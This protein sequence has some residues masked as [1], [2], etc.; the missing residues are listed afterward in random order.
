VTPRGLGGLHARFPKGWIA[1]YNQA[2]GCALRAMLATFHSFTMDLERRKC[3]SLVVVVVVQEEED[4]FFKSCRQI[5]T[6]S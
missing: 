2:L 5:E 3:S 6:N 1:T 4:G